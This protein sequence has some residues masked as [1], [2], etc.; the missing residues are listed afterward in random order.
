MLIPE[1][2]YKKIAEIKDKHITFLTDN[3]GNLYLINKKE[4]CKY[5]N[6]GEKQSEYS[7]NQLGEISFADVS[8]PLRI[9]LFYKDFNKLVFLN[10]ELSELSSHIEMDDLDGIQ[11]DIACT[12]SFGGFW[13]YDLF[14]GKLKYFDKTLKKKHESVY[15]NS[16]IKNPYSPDFIMEKNDY[17]YLHFPNSGIMLF[18]RFGAYYKTIPIKNINKFQI[19]NKNIVYFSNDK[20]YSYNPNLL[21]TDS[22][23]L[24]VSD[25]KY[26][27][28]EKGLLY[29][30]KGDEILVFEGKT[31]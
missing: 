23:S 12:S 1:T 10:N 3:L 14:D 6:K 26:A 16:L 11:A 31:F 24:P 8:D 30:S 5:S 4:I 21:T 18:D 25:C 17:L 27:R 9:T 7:N 15:I 19:V 13:V 29:V 2:E 20:L 28:I 22:L